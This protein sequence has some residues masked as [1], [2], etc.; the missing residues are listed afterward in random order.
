M[1][2]NMITL[3]AVSQ[4]LTILFSPRNQGK[5]NTHRKRNLGPAGNDITYFTEETLHLV[6]DEV[7][8]AL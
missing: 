8:G 3:F 1:N 6:V 2:V 7:G 4:R 5:N